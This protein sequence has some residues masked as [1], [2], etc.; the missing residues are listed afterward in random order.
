MG[1]V[2]MFNP[3][4][5]PRFNVDYGFSDFYLALRSVFTGDAMD[6]TVV[7][8][9]F[10][11]KPVFFTSSGRAAIY[12]LL[13]ALRL[14]PGSK[15]GVPLYTCPSV[16]EAIL[17]A[18]CVP[19]FVDISFEN[20]TVDLRDLEGKLGEINALI[21]IHTFG[22]PAEMDG[23]LE[24]AGDLP[25]IEDCA[26]SLLSRYKGRL[27]G[28]MGDA[29]IFSFRSGKYISAGE[30]GMIIVN[31][32]ELVEAVEGEI[33]R[34]SG[35][36]VLSELKHVGF[37]YVKS[38]LY[39][40]PW[41]GLFARAVAARLDSRLNISGK[42]GFKAGKIRKSDLAVLLRKLSG[43]KEL[44]EKQRENSFLLMEELKDAHLTLPFE[45]ADTYCNYYLFPVLFESCAA[46]DEAHLS[47]Q[48]LGVDTA[49]LY[50]ETPGIAR[51][52]YGYRG[53]CEQAEEL[54]RRVLII[55]N[56]YT[57]GVG[58]VR[59]IAGKVREVALRCAC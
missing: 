39:H 53:D 3:A 55:P 31:D 29:S 24:I 45:A 26:H 56:Y 9:L 50:S 59:G 21:V 18:G 37:V 17:Q 14:A 35:S 58:E 44:V 49:R 12:V 22:R 11:G 1:R 23:I 46:R 36:S 2:F 38:S 51:A 54:A 15:V 6:D 41:Y 25:V 4:L 32:A 8:E 20:Y 33:A 40:R 27:T 42:Q 13:R 57:L 7:S 30:G 52:R 19:R 47:L 10:Q 34:L 28:T 48:R 16:V 43:F 5:I